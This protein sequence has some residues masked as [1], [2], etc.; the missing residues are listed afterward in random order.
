[1]LYLLRMATDQEQTVPATL[2][3]ASASPRRAELLRQ[4]KLTF[5]VQ[6]QQVNEGRPPDEP[7]AAYV[8][9][10]ARVKAQAGWEASGGELP[11]LGADTVVALGEEH[12]GKPVDQAG[13]AAMLQKLGGRTHRVLT[14]V[15]VVQGQREAGLL[16]ISEVDFRAIDP[17]EARRYWA[18]GEPA[19]KA[20]AYAIQGLG[21]IFV[22]ELRGSYSGVMGLPLF[23]TAELLVQFGIRVLS[24]PC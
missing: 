15:H 6:P 23:E 2:I 1:M 14:A 10:L 3:L 21:A 24:V 17:D 9:R 4:L 20:G 8:S 12:L 7:V 22:R 11:V 19:D 18:S 5:V 16:S 13:A